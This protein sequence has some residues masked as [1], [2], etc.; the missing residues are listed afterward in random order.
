MK[1]K[2]KSSLIDGEWYENDVV[3]EKANKVENFEKGF[4]S[5]KIIDKFLFLKSLKKKRTSLK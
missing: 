5:D 1:Q 2:L 4:I 3:K